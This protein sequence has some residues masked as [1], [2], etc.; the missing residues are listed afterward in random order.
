MLR[1]AVLLFCVCCISIM[2]A[3][4][5][6]ALSIIREDY[7]NNSQEIV[8]VKIGDRYFRFPESFFYS[9]EDGLPIA[10]DYIR[11]HVYLP[12]FKTPVDMPSEIRNSNDFASPWMEYHLS[13]SINIKEKG[14][15]VFLY[16]GNRNL[17]PLT[18]EVEIQ[19]FGQDVSIK[20]IKEKLGSYIFSIPSKDWEENQVLANS[21]FIKKEHDDSSFCD[22]KQKVDSPPP[23][24]PLSVIE[25]GL[26]H[27][28]LAMRAVATQQL[29]RHQN[30]PEIA[31]KLYEIAKNDK[32]YYVRLIA[33]RAL[34]EYKSSVAVGPLLIER[35]LNEKNQ[36]IIRKLEQILSPS[37][38]QI[39]QAIL[40]NLDQ[41]KG[42][43][44]YQV[45]MLLASSINYDVEQNKIT[46]YS[47][48]SAVSK[49]ALDVII[50]SYENPDFHEEK[51]QISGNLMASGSAIASPRY[52]QYMMSQNAFS[53]LGALAAIPEVIVPYLIRVFQVKDVDNYSDAASALGKFGK[54]ANPALPYLLAL[55]ED[56]CAG[57]YTIR[58]LAATN[59]PTSCET[60]TPFYIRGN[61]ISTIGD[62]GVSS[63]Q[64]LKI[65][66]A[67]LEQYNEV[68]YPAAMALLKLE[69]DSN[70]LLTKLVRLLNNADEA[71][72]RD[73]IRIFEKIGTKAQ[74]AL[75][76]L[77]K[78]Q[79]KQPNND[80][81]RFVIMKISG[82]VENA[83]E[84]PVC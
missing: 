13:M 27:K 66:Y 56:K 2:T 72:Q 40:D 33:L 35:Y 73:I 3:T 78:L 31:H 65:L 83:I 44:L 58:K 19:N 54:D 80:E 49:Q 15:D 22:K 76:A 81:L 41:F 84:T 71:N 32:Q 57:S 23:L 5:A 10:R 8:E 46:H 70:R 42:E 30:F 25:K 67:E 82:E 51:R 50:D 38:A 63:P 59:S 29:A 11:I 21:L 36:S 16:S 61:I 47:Q 69:S 6:M 64:I 14:K 17:H 18:K 75:S 45:L 52:I 12:D 48:L 9:P 1:S 39:A 55:L 53:Q 28:N 20:E 24:A 68:R 74:P 62:I 4:K 60:R 34:S 43:K 37:H 26:V 77:E 79:R 7:S